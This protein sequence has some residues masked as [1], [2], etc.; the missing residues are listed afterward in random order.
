MDNETPKELKI[1]KVHLDSF[2]NV[3]V[4]LYDRGVNYVDIIGVLD[5]KQDMVGLSFSR[6]YMSEEQRKNF[7]S[8]PINISH[9]GN[10]NDVHVRFSDDEDLNQII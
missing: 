10:N 2:I 4:D 7:D 9:K 1:R 6:E 3:L 8:I 5:G